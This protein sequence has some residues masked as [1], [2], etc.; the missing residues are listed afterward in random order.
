MSRIVI[1]CARTE[2]ESE[3]SS[4]LC[5]SP[6]ILSSDLTSVFSSTFL[7]IRKSL[8]K[9]CGKHPSELFPVQQNLCNMG[10]WLL[11]AMQVENR[12]AGDYT[13]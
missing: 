6:R 1:L 13:Q 4:V 7:K 11:A 3:I 2:P 12:V 10:N 8:F 5:P 9:E